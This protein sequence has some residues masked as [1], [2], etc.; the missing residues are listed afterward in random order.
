MVNVNVTFKHLAIRRAKIKIADKTSRSVMSNATTSGFC[1]ALISVDCNLTNRAFDENFCD[2][3][4]FG[5]P[6]FDIFDYAK[7]LEGGC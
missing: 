3:Y 6:T 7:F 5:Q 1:I 2:I 4:F